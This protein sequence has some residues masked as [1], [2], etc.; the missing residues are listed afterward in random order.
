[1]Q[2][3]L[4]MIL[5]KKLQAREIQF[6]EKEINSVLIL[7]IKITSEYCEHYKYFYHDQTKIN[8][9]F[10]NQKT[11]TNNYEKATVN[12]SCN[13]EF[14]IC[15]SKPNASSNKEKSNG[16]RGAGYRRQECSNPFRR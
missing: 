8:K 14:I 10:I 6:L 15:N 13:Y 2:N 5:R 1:M 7:S 3:G 16:V 9:H 4:M 12:G 11:K